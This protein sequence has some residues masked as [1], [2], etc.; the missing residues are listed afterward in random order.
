[1][2]IRIKKYLPRQLEKMDSFMI[3]RHMDP[4]LSVEGKVNIAQIV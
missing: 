4:N 1:M 3:N 2:D